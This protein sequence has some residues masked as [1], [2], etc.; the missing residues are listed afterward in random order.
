MT[1]KIFN[2]LREHKPII[3]NYGKGIIKSDE[4]IKEE[5]I[6]DDE[7]KKYRSETGIWSNNLLRE[8]ANGEVEGISIEL[9][10]LLDGIRNDS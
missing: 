7:I 4:E 2:H 1:E 10:E 9:E 3:V 8:I 5:A 6:Y